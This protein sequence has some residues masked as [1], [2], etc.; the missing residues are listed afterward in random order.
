MNR[1]PALR[2]SFVNSI[3]QLHD[4]APG[5][6]GPGER[7]RREVLLA[8]IDALRDDL[9]RARLR[10]GLA[11]ASAACAAVGAIAVVVAA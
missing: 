6:G 1:D 5:C 9:R 10:V 8:E 2:R 11:A 4:V 3:R 7:M